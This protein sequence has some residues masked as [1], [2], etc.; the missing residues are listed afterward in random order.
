MAKSPNQMWIKPLYKKLAPIFREVLTM[1]AFINIMALAGPIFTLQ[2]YDRVVQHA[3]ISTLGGLVLGMGLIVLFDY[4]LKNSRSRIMQTVALRVDAEVGRAVFEKFTSL[5]LN[6]LES[7]PANHWQ[8]MFRDVDAVRNTLSGGSAILLCDLPFAILFF[9]LIAVIATPIIWVLGIVIPIFLLITYRAGKATGS[10][11]SQEASTSRDRDSLIAEMINGRATIKALALEGSMR[12]MWEERHATNIERAIF[13]G[14]RTDTFTNLGQSLTTVTTIAMTSFGALMIIS[15]DLTMGALIASNMLMGR[16]LGPLNQLVSQWRTYSSYNQ[17]V[18]RLG[19]MF[20]IESERQV[21]DVQMSK[22]K[23]RIECSNLTFAY[24]DGLPPVCD[25]VTVSFDEGGIHALVGRNGSG[26]TTLLKMIQGLYRPS[27][28]RVLLDGAD[29]A[30][31]S[32]V[33]LARWM[34][35]VPQESTLFAGTVRDNI[36]HRFPEATDAE[37]IIA[38]KAAG[39]HDFIIDLPDG[40]GADIG[41][42]GRRLSGGQRQ[43]IAI[44]RALIGDPSVLLLD[45]PSSSLDRHAE[46]DLR[47]TLRELSRQHTII[48]VT[49]SPILLA[50]CDNLVALDKGKVALA[51]SSKDILPRLF[52]GA[53]PVAAEAPLKDDTPPAPPPTETAP[54]PAKTATPLPQSKAQAPSAKPVAKP[55]P[56]PTPKPAPPPAE[57]PKAPLARP[58]LAGAP[59]KPAGPATPVKAS[60][61]VAKPAPKSGLGKPAMA[62]PKSAPKPAKPEEE[63]ND[64]SADKSNAAAIGSIT[65]VKKEVPV[66]RQTDFEKKTDVEKP[67][68]PAVKA[69]ELP[70]EEKPEEA[71]KAPEKKS[72][73]QPQRK[74]DDDPYAD[75]IVSLAHDRDNPAP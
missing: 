55:T 36:T 3:G 9:G 27:N 17:A 41:E 1:S 2:V 43:R 54:P 68:S 39:V 40:Y 24:A 61:P 16:L 49:H 5:P 44:A 4:V 7:R 74:G 65:P 63:S 59:P 38:S 53:V 45:E 20:S 25:N 58:A 73:L 67:A 69:P 66:E 48:I 33:E 72:P 23:G 28:G 60:A 46:Q 57:K 30:Q 34:G 10:A 18:G 22:P 13:R 14:G 56:K 70:P 64:Q 62:K 51:G 11:N 12:P 19:E 29:I 6:V 71:P 15:Q 26:K 21:S 42:A 8:A 32:R 37:I 47:E 31:F 75:A 50:A 52:G 35:Y